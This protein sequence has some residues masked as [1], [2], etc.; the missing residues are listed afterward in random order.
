MYIRPEGYQI[1][2]TVTLRTAAVFYSFQYTRKDCRSLNKPLMAMQ[3]SVVKYKFV[4]L[5]VYMASRVQ[6]TL[7]LVLSDHL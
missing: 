5:K 6:Q 7:T 4:T 2:S 1:R 3:I